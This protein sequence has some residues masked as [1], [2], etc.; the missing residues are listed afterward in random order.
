M[1]RKSKP[2]EKSQ[3]KIYYTSLYYS[4]KY[5]PIISLFLEEKKLKKK[6][7]FSIIFVITKIESNKIQ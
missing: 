3:P 7:N 4:L 1:S 2:K 5:R 6:T